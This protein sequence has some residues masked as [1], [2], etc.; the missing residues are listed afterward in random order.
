M[1]ETPPVPTAIN[2]HT[3]TVGCSTDRTPQKFLEK[4]A[5]PVLCHRVPPTIL[6]PI[7]QG[8]QFQIIPMRCTTDCGKANIYTVNDIP[9]WEQAC[10]THKIQFR[11]Q[12][13]EEKAKDSAFNKKD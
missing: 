8:S 10:D 11:L 5:R 13:A 4:D 6:P 1:A 9:F 7:V 3:Y 2:T 12:S